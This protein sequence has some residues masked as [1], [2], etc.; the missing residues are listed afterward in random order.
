MCR[1]LMAFAGAAAAVAAIAATPATAFR[2][3]GSVTVNKVRF[4]VSV[5]RGS[6]ACGDAGAAI[7]AFVE[8]GPRTA[9]GPSAGSFAQKSWTVRG[10][11]TCKEGTGGGVCFFGG[12][13][14]LKVSNPRYVVDYA[15]LP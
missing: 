5:Y 9:H 1:R 12:S 11:W 10:G 15:F 4:H 2:S 6:V 3:C 8:P 13:G 7:K 14:P